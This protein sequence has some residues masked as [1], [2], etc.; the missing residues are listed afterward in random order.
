[1][2]IETDNRRRYIIAD[3]LSES[4]AANWRAAAD[5]DGH[6]SFAVAL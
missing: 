5:E 1:M 6:Y 3:V 2:N 4:S